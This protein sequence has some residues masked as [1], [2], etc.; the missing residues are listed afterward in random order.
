MNI[1]H[2][3]NSLSKP[4]GIANVAVDISTYQKEMGMNVFI[5][6]SGGELL[7]VLNAHETPHIYFNQYATIQN[8]STVIFKFIKVINN[9]KPD[10]IHC[11]MISGFLIAKA[12]QPFFSY[13]IVAHLHNPHENKSK[14]LKYADIIIAISDN[15]KDQ[16][17]DWGCSTKKIRTVLNRTL[18]SNTRKFYAS[19]ASFS[20]RHPNVVTVGGL[21]KRKGID[22]VIN[23]FSSLGEKHSD[24]HLYIVGEGPDRVTFETIAK[25]SR[26][27]DR[28]H[29]IGYCS[30]PSKYLKQ[31]DI[32]CLASRAEGYGLVINEAREEGCAIVASNVGGIPEALANGEHGVLF[33]SENVDELARHFDALLSDEKLMND[34]KAKA[35]NNIELFSVSDMVEQVNEIYLELLTKKSIK[36]IL[37]D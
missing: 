8:L 16:L 1:L 29:F 25:Q 5:G 26:A 31:A 6:S 14:T 30:D 17:L 11:H 10:I 33:E 28:I 37:K 27:L 32:F 18:N 19:T 15:V 13:S 21:Y 35:L 20:L 23:A 9:T 22:I 34:Y 12:L 24:L 3:L 7:D 36:N 4:N 2:L